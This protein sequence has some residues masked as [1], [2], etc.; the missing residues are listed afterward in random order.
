MHRSTVVVMSVL[1]M[2]IVGG[3]VA[4][5]ITQRENPMLK[6]VVHINFGGTEGQKQGLNNIENILKDV[7]DAELEVV[8]HSE[9]I[10]LVTKQGS[11]APELI[12][13]LIKQGVKF[14]A[15]ENTLK[16]KSL[17][18][19]DLVQGVSTVAS[20]AVEVIQKQSDGYSYFRP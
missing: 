16:K 17:T 2:A 4:Q 10:T 11:P 3:A 14:V 6:A 18:K 12:G 20:G 8:C 7:P 1:L 13:T 15:C 5:Q 9:G 19:N